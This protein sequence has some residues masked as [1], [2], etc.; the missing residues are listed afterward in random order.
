MSID[1]IKN[2][3]S[4]PVTDID[5]VLREIKSINLKKPYKRDISPYKKF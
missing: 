4:L 1:K 5:E 3:H 2:I